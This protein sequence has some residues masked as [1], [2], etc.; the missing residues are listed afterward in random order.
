MIVDS[1]KYQFLNE[2][3]AHWLHLK[4]VAASVGAIRKA[5]KMIGAISRQM[6]K[7]KS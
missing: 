2:R 7:L 4:S 1:E 3:L 5:N 6:E